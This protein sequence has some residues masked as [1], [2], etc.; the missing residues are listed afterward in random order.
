MQVASQLLLSS[1]T[2]CNSFT[3]CGTFSQLNSLVDEKPKQRT[4][5]SV[6]VIHKAWALCKSL[7]PARRTE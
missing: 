1:I 7:H 5:Q 2:P 4:H 3:N 6:V